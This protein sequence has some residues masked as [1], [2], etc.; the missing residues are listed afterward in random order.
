MASAHRERLSTR[1]PAVADALDALRAKRPAGHHPDEIVAMLD[2]V[3]DLRPALNAASEEELIEISQAVDLTIM[4]T[5]SAPNRCLRNG[6]VE[7]PVGEM[8]AGR[9]HR[10][11]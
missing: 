8:R 9:H 1:K 11:A 7:L 10:P 3:P 4:R 5:E 2:A 6:G